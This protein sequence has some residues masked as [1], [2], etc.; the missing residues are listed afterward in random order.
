MILYNSS[1]ILRYLWG[2]HGHKEEAQFLKPSQEALELEKKID[3]MGSDIRVWAYYQLL[4][5]PDN[6]DEVALKIWGNDKIQDV[7]EHC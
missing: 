3:K 7:S 1:D 2:C 5:L 6:S 4:V